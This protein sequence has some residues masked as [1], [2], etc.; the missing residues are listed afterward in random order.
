MCGGVLLC[1]CVSLHTIDRA[2]RPTIERTLNRLYSSGIKNATV[3]V[4]G[5]N[6]SIDSATRLT[7][8]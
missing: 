3:R 7:N 5:F 1:V 8:E 4:C 2:N 6:T